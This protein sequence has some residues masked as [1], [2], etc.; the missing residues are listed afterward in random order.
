VRAGRILRGR[1]LSTR[2]GGLQ[3]P[4]VG[5]VRS[6]PRGAGYLR[7][8]QQSLFRRY[9]SVRSRDVRERMRVSRD[10]LQRQLRGAGDRRHELRILRD[11][12]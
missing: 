11:G 8:V 9:T 3:R 5:R 4:G 10:E 12:L 7:V 6:Q 2:L 1:I